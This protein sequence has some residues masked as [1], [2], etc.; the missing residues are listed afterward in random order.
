M[1]R[2]IIRFQKVV[3][4][5]FEFPRDQAEP[6]VCTRSLGRPAAGAH[7]SQ[8]ETVFKLF[9]WS[10]L[11]RFFS[12]EHFDGHN[13][14]VYFKITISYLTNQIWRKKVFLHLA[15]NNL[16]LNEKNSFFTL[17][18]QLHALVKVCFFL[19]LCCLHLQKSK[20]RAGKYP[21]REASA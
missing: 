6:G 14:L 8:V 4:Q 2:A 9:L 5:V 21:E 13:T 20:P 3:L 10:V 18:Y 12:L 17:C 15:Q 11:Y 19:I 16:F 7:L 1:Y